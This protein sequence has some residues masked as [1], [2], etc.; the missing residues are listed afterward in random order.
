MHSKRKEIAAII[1]PVLQSKKELLKN[2][3][4]DSG[5]IV[6]FYLDELLPTELALNIRASFPDPSLMRI[7]KS[8]R[9]LKFIGAYMDQYN[10]LLG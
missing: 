5:K 8:L 10:P 6:H 2:L 9:E 4:N 1:L 3:Y 7:K